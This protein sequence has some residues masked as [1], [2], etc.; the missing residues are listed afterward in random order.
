VR[1]FFTYTVGWFRAVLRRVMRGSPAMLEV[2][3]GVGEWRL[4]EKFV[5]AGER[6]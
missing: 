3:K 6:L 4:A 1:R 5:Q 2:T